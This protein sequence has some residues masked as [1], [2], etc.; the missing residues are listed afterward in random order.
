[1][2]TTAIYNVTFTRPE[3]HVVSDV[4][5]FLIESK[6]S[7]LDAG[8]LTDLREHLDGLTLT[9]VDSG[10]IATLIEAL[11]FTDTYCECSDD[12]TTAEAEAMCERSRVIGKELRA[13]IGWKSDAPTVDSRKRAIG[14]LTYNPDPKRPHPWGV[15]LADAEGRSTGQRFAIL[16]S[17]AEGYTSG[18]RVI[19]RYVPD[20][21]FATIEGVAS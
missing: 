18:Q 19:V 1:M 13:L 7:P 2:K 9:G 21:Q 4:L 12:L 5:G 11:D 20:D 15:S 16:D 14:Y 3:F 6:E 10:E 8:V 17:D